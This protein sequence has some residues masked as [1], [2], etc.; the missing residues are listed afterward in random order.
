MFQIFKQIGEWD[1]SSI[2]PDWMSHGLECA[3]NIAYFSVAFPK[4][5][6]SSFTNLPYR[7]QPKLAIRLAAICRI[8]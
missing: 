1:V 8:R 3:T 4:K 7:L 6:T 2:C 5:N